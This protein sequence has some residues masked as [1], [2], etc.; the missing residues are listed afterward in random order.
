MAFLLKFRETVK[1]T[2]ESN[3][4]SNQKFDFWCN[5]SLETL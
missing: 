2:K 3:F 5:I 4:S 1:G